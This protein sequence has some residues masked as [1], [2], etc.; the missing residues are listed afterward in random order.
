MVLGIGN[1]RSDVM[2]LGREESIE[3]I[4]KKNL[5]AKRYQEKLEKLR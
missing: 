1:K 2:I 4:T 5:K 3:Q